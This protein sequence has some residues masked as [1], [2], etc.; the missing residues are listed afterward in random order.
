MFAT[1]ACCLVW[2]GPAPRIRVLVLDGI[3]GRPIPKLEVE[4]SYQKVNGAR[5]VSARTGRDGVA[6]F[7]LPKPIG[8]VLDFLPALT[9]DYP[10]CSAG[11]AMTRL[12]LAHG[13]VQ[14]SDKTGYYC[15]RKKGW[16]DPE[17]QPGEFVVFVRHRRWWEWLTW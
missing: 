2:P 3:N 1:P 17:P 13:V 6:M 4:L 11:L 8:R 10:G 16:Q 14:P 9:P 7:T 15:R 5:C 12:V